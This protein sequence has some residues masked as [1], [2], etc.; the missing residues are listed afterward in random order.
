MDARV[1]GWRARGIVG[2]LNCCASPALL[3]PWIVTWASS[4]A[5][6]VVESVPVSL[7]VVV[8]ASAFIVCDVPLAGAVQS[9]TPFRFVL[10]TAPGLCFEVLI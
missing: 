9:T 5:A 2:L 6:T 7:A 1:L 10:E 8:V 3:L 4:A